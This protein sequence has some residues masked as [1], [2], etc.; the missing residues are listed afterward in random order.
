M[1]ETKL[2]EL[3]RHLETARIMFEQDVEN[4]AY[5]FGKKCGK[6]LTD[7][8]IIIAINKIERFDEHC[9]T[10]QEFAL[11]GAKEKRNE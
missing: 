3:E 11:K 2:D 7:D 5:N 9:R 1:N 4:Y 8:E 6:E 10:M